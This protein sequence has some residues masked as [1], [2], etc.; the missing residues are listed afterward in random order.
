[1]IYT[2]LAQLSSITSNA[3]NALVSSKQI[4]FKYTHLKQFALI[5]RS[6]M[7][8][9]REFQTVGRTG[10]KAEMELT[11]A[12]DCSNMLLV[13]VQCTCLYRLS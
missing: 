3:L 2:G 8:S 13:G 4:R 11:C 9:G 7:K 1:M 10:N 12:I 6:R 5:V